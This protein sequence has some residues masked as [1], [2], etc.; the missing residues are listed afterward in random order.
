MRRFEASRPLDFVSAKN[1]GIRHNHDFGFFAEET[2]SEGAKM[3]LQALAFGLPWSAGNLRVDGILD[4]F[5][6]RVF[7]AVFAPDLAESLALAVVVA[8]ELNGIA[9]SEPA[10]E[11]VEEFPAL[12][13]GN[14]RFRGSL[15]QRPECV[16]GCELGNAKL[17]LILQ[18]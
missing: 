4:G 11:L 7:E 1:L 16:K 8:E 10:V 2:A 15:G 12:S 3:S 9:L 5:R 17:L 14:L 18:L 13:L 6:V